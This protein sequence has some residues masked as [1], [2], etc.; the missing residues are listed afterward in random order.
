MSKTKNSSA[1][2]NGRRSYLKLQLINLGVY[3]VLFMLLCLIAVSTDIKKEHTLYAALIYIGIASF[4]SGFI[5]GLKERKNGILCGI[6]GSLPLN[7]VLIFAS[8]ISNGFSIDLNILYS[9]LT[10][11]MCGVIGGI[12]SVNIRL[13]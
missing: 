11:L 3:A 5:F 4:V 6:F 1:S 7:I 2:K 10:G 13:R 12:V 9:L 8:L